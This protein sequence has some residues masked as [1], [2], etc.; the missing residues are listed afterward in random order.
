MSFSTSNHPFLNVAS[1]QPAHTSS[2]LLGWKAQI[3]SLWQA[4][5][6]PGVDVT[7]VASLCILLREPEAR[8]R[9][10]FDLV[11]MA[12]V[13]TE[14]HLSVDRP[15]LSATWDYMEPTTFEKAPYVRPQH[16]KF[17]CPQCNERPDGFRGEHELDRHISR[18]HA[19]TRKGYICIDASEDKRFLSNCKYCRNKKVYGAYYNA[20]AH[21]RRAH[22]HPRKRGRKGKD[23]Q[24]EGLGAGNDP[25]MDMLRQYWISEV[26]VPN[27]RNYASGGYQA[28]EKPSSEELG[29]DDEDHLVHPSGNP[30]EP[31]AAVG[32]DHSEVDMYYRKAEAEYRRHGY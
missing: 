19:K 2:P 18:A 23:E 29:K 30:A 32:L 21:L 8:V 17:K 15:N 14:D 13:Y 20:A 12:P 7:E 24:R 16:P 3:V 11:S 5:S 9:S 25:S 26:E 1:R 22:F 28:G 10:Q 27:E 6:P 31:Q 4:N